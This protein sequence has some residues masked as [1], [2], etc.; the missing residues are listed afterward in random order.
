MSATNEIKYIDINFEYDV[1]TNNNVLSYSS[2]GG[3]TVNYTYKTNVNRKATLLSINKMNDYKYN[4]PQYNTY[5][6]ATNKLC[7]DTF[8]G[9]VKVLLPKNAVANE[10][11]N[12]Y[13]FVSVSA[14]RLDNGKIDMV[15]FSELP[16]VKINNIC[17]TVFNDGD[18]RYP[19][20]ISK[21][22]WQSFK[23]Q[24]EQGNY[25]I[26][27]STPIY[28]NTEMTGICD[29]YDFN[30]TEYDNLLKFTNEFYN[31][32]SVDDFIPDNIPD[33]TDDDEEP[34]N[35]DIHTEPVID[36]TNNN[37]DDSK[38]SNN[39]TDDSKQ[40]NNDIYC[41]SILKDTVKNYYMTFV[42]IWK[43]HINNK[44]ELNEPYFSSRC[45]ING[46]LRTFRTE[47]EAICNTAFIEANNE[48]RDIYEKKYEEL[49]K[50]NRKFKL[51]PSHI[52]DILYPS[53]DKTEC[54]CC[55][56]I[57]TKENFEMT[58]CGHNICKSCLYQLPNDKCPTCKATIEDKIF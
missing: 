7:Y 20:N 40:S 57:P 41:K 14:L 35:M 34:I 37:V 58:V 52:K 51:Q 9:I 29:T 27:I 5:L 15:N 4:H 30:M 1:N 6:M 50:Y 44:T 2:F 48:L 12:I 11:T 54:P 25:K 22:Y 53:F 24:K 17:E 33:D 8:R 46:S 39:N 36:L 26:C 32:N 10:N 43:E 28:S 3:N 23:L 18:C 45:I 47:V 56:D 19:E 49:K 21:I 31:R 42:N 55:M 16:V 13:G 38:Q